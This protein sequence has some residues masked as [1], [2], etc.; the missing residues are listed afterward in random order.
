MTGFDMAPPSAPGGANAEAESWAVLEDIDRQIE[1]VVLA[2]QNPITG[3]LPASTANTVHGNYGDAWVR[4]CVYS[5]QCVWGLAMA[6]TR[7][8]G[9]GRRAFE[10]EQRVVQLMRGLLNAMLRQAPKVERFKHSLEP[11]DALHAKYDTGSGEPVVPDDGW[12]HLQLDATALFPPQL[13]QLTRPGLVV[14]Q[15]SHERDFI[16]NLVYYV[17]RA[18]RVADYGI[19]ER[20]DKGNH[21]L[22]ERNA[23][24][25]GLVKAALEALGL[26]FEV[27]EALEDDF[28]CAAGLACFDH[29]DI[30]AVGLGAAAGTK[31]NLPLPAGAGDAAF[32]A[33]WTQVAAHLA[34]VLQRDLQKDPS[35]MLLLSL[36]LHCFQSGL[37]LPGWHN[38]YSGRRE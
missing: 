18:Y 36:P 33:A 23:S 32:H 13:A 6:H 38:R 2:R 15:T 21:G 34:Q 20:G 17:A 26:V 25:I 31:L 4:D 9:H 8:G 7:L 16:Q 12:G 19:W 29:V 14:V 37:W 35:S 5:I 1:A 3:L 10:L 30:E 28:E 11:L 22:P 24:S 27:C